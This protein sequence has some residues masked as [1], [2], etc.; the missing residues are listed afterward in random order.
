MSCCWG[1]VAAGS[2]REDQHER[3]QYSVPVAEKPLL[4]DLEVT[5]VQREIENRKDDVQRT[6]KQDRCKDLS[7]RIEELLKGV[8]TAPDHIAL[9]ES[10]RCVDNQL[11][12]M[13]LQVW[14][15]L[16]FVIS[17]AVSQ[18]I[19]HHPLKE[20]RVPQ[21]LCRLL[22]IRDS[23]KH[24]LGIEIVRQALEELRLDRH[25]VSCHGEIIIQFVVCRQDDTL[26]CISGHVMNR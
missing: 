20:V 24:D 9:V 19:L 23:T 18:G 17:N 25:L 1:C 13:L 26:T 22:D 15:V 5:T 6:A 4:V 21:P 10:L 14:V 2:N 8:R 12:A 3:N 16:L 7:L 11:P